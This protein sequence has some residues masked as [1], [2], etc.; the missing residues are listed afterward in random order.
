M[1]LLDPIES[2][3][4]KSVNLNAEDLRQLPFVFEKQFADEI[5]ALYYFHLF[6]DHGVITRMSQPAKYY[7]SFKH[8]Q[9]ATLSSPKEY[10]SSII[11]SDKNEPLIGK[12]FYKWMEDIGNLQKE[13]YGTFVSNVKHLN[14]QLPSTYTNV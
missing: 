1:R 6:Y 13:I 10:L 9:S 5:S 4:S 12:W 2:I 14:S 3:S 8:N 7:P 11:Q